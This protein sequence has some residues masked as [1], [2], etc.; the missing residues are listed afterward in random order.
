M[1]ERRTGQPGEPPAN[2]AA[3]D[4]LTVAQAADQLGISEGAVRSRIKR[5]TLQ[6]ERDS[7]TVYVVL[8]G[9]LGADRPTDVPPAD[10][11]D[12]SER[13]DQRLISSYEAR[14]ESLER[15]LQAERE[16]H[17]ESRRIIAGL[18]QRIPELEAPPQSAQEAQDVAES[19]SEGESGEE[20]SEAHTEPQ[21]RRPW[22][23]S[24][25]R[26]FGNPRSRGG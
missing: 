26:I 4:R 20:D 7:G 17:G 25:K 9:A 14:I 23:R 5:G 24:L 15:Q 1:G 3:Y 6:T 12:Q 2:E 10:H 16:A 13:E 22:W 11:T 18:V 19:A 8:A 21:E